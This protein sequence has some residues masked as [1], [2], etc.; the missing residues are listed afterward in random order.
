MKSTVYVKVKVTPG[1]SRTEFCSLLGDGYSKINL[2]AKP[3]HGRANAELVKWISEQ[4]G[5]R[6]DAVVI[7]SGKTY[8]RKTLKVISPSSIPLWFNG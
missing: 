1:R 5:V 8:R 3:V 6:I 4:F 2:K 7:K